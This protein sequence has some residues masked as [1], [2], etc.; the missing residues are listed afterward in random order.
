MSWKGK[1]GFDDERIYHQCEL[2]L[3]WLGARSWSI[4]EGSSSIISG[5]GASGLKIMKGIH[6]GDAAILEEMEKSWHPWDRD[7]VFNHYSEGDRFYSDVRKNP[8]AESSDE[9]ESSTN[10]VRFT[11][12]TTRSL[13]ATFSLA[14]VWN[15]VWIMQELAYSPRIHLVTEDIEVDWE[16]ITSF[17]YNRNIK[18]LLEKLSQ[19]TGKRLNLADTLIQFRCTE[20]TDPRDKIYA[21]LGL[22]SEPHGIDVDYKK[23]TQEI[24]T[25]VALVLINTTLTLDIICQN[26]WYPPGSRHISDLPSWVPD[27]TRGQSSSTLYYNFLFAQRSV[28]NAG[29]PFCKSPCT[30]LNGSIIRLEGVLLGRIDRL[31]QEKSPFTSSRPCMQT[32]MEAMFQDCVANDPSSQFMTGGESCFRAFWRILVMDYKAYPIQR[33]TPEEVE[34]D[35]RRFGKW[36][37]NISASIPAIEGESPG[38]YGHGIV[39]MKLL[40]RSAKNW[41]F[42]VT[43]DGFYVMAAES[44]RDGTKAGDVLAVLDGGKVPVVLRPIEDSSP[45]ARESFRVIHVAYVHG[46]MDGEAQWTKKLVTRG[47][48]KLAFDSSSLHVI[49]DSSSTI[50][51]KHTGNPSEAS[52]II[53][54]D[55]E[56]TSFV[57]PDRQW[58]VVEGTTTT[59]LKP[60]EVQFILAIPIVADRSTAVPNGQTILVGGTTCYVQALVPSSNQGHTSFGA[61]V[62]SPTNSKTL[63]SSLIT[64]AFTRT[65][66]DGPTSVVRAVE[67]EFQDGT[68]KSQLVVVGG[69]I[70]SRPNKELTINGG[71]TTVVPVLGTMDHGALVVVIGGTARSVSDGNR[72]TSSGITIITT[73]HVSL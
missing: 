49:V 15:R 62:T 50:Q 56:G 31:G 46:F 40:E 37:T 34:S 16:V 29:I 69:Q 45:S 60:S 13:R 64:G 20:A 12:R 28:F 1:A 72:N 52:A 38:G 18:A 33:L 22:I 9:E 44:Y 4:F 26:H 57:L 6:Q 7:R 66:A 65:L 10:Q 54:V 39:S 11:A 35:D 23:S 53:H 42:G 36:L 48:T 59:V 25:K 32:W 51:L 17:L 27:F 21:L 68:S 67:V 63:R 2:D 58:G 41:C 73:P 55:F 47:G 43:E 5:S 70:R 14:T 24:F 3:V 71:T 30:V 61:A 19:T 8:D